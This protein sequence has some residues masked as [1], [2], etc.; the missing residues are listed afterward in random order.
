MDYRVRHLCLIKK[1]L[2]MPQHANE[3]AAHLP[4]FGVKIPEV[5]TNLSEKLLKISPTGID[6]IFFLDAG[7]PAIDAS[8]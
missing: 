5:D 4:Q 2:L 6:K 3:R 8:I 7:S 1:N